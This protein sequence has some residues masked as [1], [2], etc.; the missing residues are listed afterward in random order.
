MSDGTNYENPSAHEL[1]VYAPVIE[2]SDSEDIFLKGPLH[3][4]LLEGN[5]NK[6]P[7]LTGITSEEN[8][9]IFSNRYL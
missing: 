4:M 2:N 3:D 9:G 6:V 1:P 8:T 7:L 5:F